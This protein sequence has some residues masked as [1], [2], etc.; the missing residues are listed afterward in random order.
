MASGSLAHP[1][2]EY[3]ETTHLVILGHRVVASSSMTRMITVFMKTR[4]QQI[5]RLASKSTALTTAF[6]RMKQHVTGVASLS[7]S[8]LL[9]TFIETT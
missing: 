1:V 6:L 5:A 3:I 9:T 8:A 2:I 4:Q 7:S